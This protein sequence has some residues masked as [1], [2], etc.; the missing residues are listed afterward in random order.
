[1][2]T[3]RIEFDQ[4]P[5]ER[6]YFEYQQVHDLFRHYDAVS[7]TIASILL[8]VSVGLIGVSYQSAFLLHGEIAAASWLL[9]L[10]W[11][12][13]DCRLTHYTHLLR[14]RMIGIEENIGVNIH[15]HITTHENLHIPSMRQVLYP[16]LILLA[17]FW[18][19]RF[20]PNLWTIILFMSVTSYGGWLL[21]L[22]CKREQGL[23]THDPP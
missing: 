1:M 5:F 14:E 20:Y 22:Q 9:Y 11:I 7:W 10:A 4:R 12:V 13:L 2:S 8:G 19:W 17:G 15:G 16:P 23:Q 6:A 21:Y 3:E 18:V